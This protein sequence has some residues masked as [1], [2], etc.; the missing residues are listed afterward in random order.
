MNGLGTR[1]VYWWCGEWPGNEASILVSESLVHSA[2]ALF[3]V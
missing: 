1:L 2:Q 3:R